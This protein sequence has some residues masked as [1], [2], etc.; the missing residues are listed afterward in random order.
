ML[1][2]TI[3]N[4]V[5][6]RVH[7]SLFM[8]YFIMDLGRLD[9]SAQ[10]VLMFI[11]EEEDQGLSEPPRRPGSQ[12]QRNPVNRNQRTGGTGTQATTTAATG[13]YSSFIL[14]IG[15]MLRQCEHVE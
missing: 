1:F 13:I 2:I 8:F 5:V 14:M 4:G 15:L 12:V 11:L 3:N 10:E 9:V 6:S 7:L